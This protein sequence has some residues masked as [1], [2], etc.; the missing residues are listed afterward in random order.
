MKIPYKGLAVI[1]AATAGTAVTNAIISNRGGSLENSIG[2]HE[3]TYR[4]RMGNIFYTVSGGGEPVLFVHGIG[5]GASSFEWR[6]NFLPLSK[7]FTVYA[8]DMVGFGMSD[9]PDIPYRSEV[10]TQLILD[11]IMDIIGRPTDIAASSHGAAYSV[12]AAHSHRLMIKRLLLSCPTGI[13]IADR[14]IPF[15]PLLS[16]GINI[17]VFG[18]SVYLGLTSINGIRSYLKTQIYAD[19]SSVTPEVIE[20]YYRSSHQPGAEYPIRAFISGALNTSIRDQ[21]SS[22]TQPV[23][24]V[25]GKQ[26]KIAP[27]DVAEHFTKA[28]PQAS[29][30]VFDQAAQLP[31]EEKADEYNQLARNVFSSP[32]EGV[33]MPQHTHTMLK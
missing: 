9:R 28:N 12:L 29:L 7:Y 8:L 32:P 21:F 14:K 33:K 26:A 4:W 15:S 5:A 22:I 11:F 3:R 2:G 30:Q 17:P 13:G 19:P 25:W 27:V 18:K 1:G 23:A 24:L 31:H 20:H 6:K 16:T 10:Y